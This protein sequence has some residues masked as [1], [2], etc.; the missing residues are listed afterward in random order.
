MQYTKIVIQGVSQIFFN[1]SLTEMLV[2]KKDRIKILGHIT[3]LYFCGGQL[4]ICKNWAAPVQ[5][6]M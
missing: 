5:P 2:Q 4:N 1:F 3:F 6:C